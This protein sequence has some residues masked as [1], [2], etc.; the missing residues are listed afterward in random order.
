MPTVYNKR[1]NDAPNDA[2]YVGRPTKWG[3]QFKIGDPHP[4]SDTGKTKMTRNDVVEWYRYYLH[5]TPELLAA[6]K[7]EL[8]GKDLVCWCAPE[9]C[10]ADVLMEIANSEA[11][12]NTNA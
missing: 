8:R 9:A 12:G 1:H 3:N 2:I 7:S 5:H 6:A 10:H 11:G 4:Q